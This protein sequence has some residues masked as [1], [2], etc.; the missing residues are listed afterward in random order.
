MSNLD[1]QQSSCYRNSKINRYISKIEKEFN[2]QKTSFRRSNRLSQKSLEN[3]NGNLVMFGKVI[4]FYYF[5]NSVQMFILNL[6]LM[7][8]RWGGCRVWVDWISSRIQLGLQIFYIM[9]LSFV[10]GF[11]QASQVCG[12]ESYYCW[13]STTYYL[14]TFSSIFSSPESE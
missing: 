10:N 3:E 7:V 9:V 4:Q 14:L 11:N 5:S 1:K 12:L 8:R 13:S 6:C 2:L